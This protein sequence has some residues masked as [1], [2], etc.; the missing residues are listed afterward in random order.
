MGLRH[1]LGSV[2]KD[3]FRRTARKCA[4]SGSVSLAEGGS[5][6]DGL[7]RVRTRLA[8]QG[9]PEAFDALVAPRRAGLLLLLAAV[10][11]D[12]HEAEDAL[13]EVLWRVFRH[14]RDLRDTEALDPW[15]RSLALNAARDHLRA[16]AARLRREGTPLGD[17]AE[18]EAL[19]G[20]RA[21]L[22]LVSDLEDEA[23][24]R[25][26]LEALTVLPP[27]QRRAGSLAWVVSLPPRQ[28]AATLGV[29]VGGVHALLHRARRRLATSLG[30]SSGAGRGARQM[31]DGTVRISGWSHRVDPLVAHWRRT[32]PDLTVERV[33]L[34]ASD[35][36]VEVR[37]FWE[38]VSS[39][40]G[41]GEDGLLPLD[42][43][44]DAAGF[45]LEPFGDRLGP[46]CRDGRPLLLPWHSS[47]SSVLYN[48]DL[49]ERAGLPAP[50][51][52]WT[53]DEFLEYCRRCTAA[54]VLAI[55]DRRMLWG[56]D[57]PV[58]AEQLGASPGNVAPFGD[59]LALVR[60]WWHAAA[61]WAP[62][63]EDAWEHD[64]YA[65]GSVFAFGQWSW[66]P[67]WG[68]AEPE[69]HPRPFRW[70]I[71]PIPRLFRSAPHLPFWERSVVGVRAA[72]ADPVRAFA[73]VQAL[74]TD[75]PAPRGGELPAY[76]TRDAMGA[77]RAAALP[78]GK[79]CLLELDG[80]PPPRH[81][82]WL[83]SVEGMR[84][85]CRSAVEG[86]I[87]IAEAVTRIEAIVK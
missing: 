77:W 66:G 31:Q 43:L 34:G 50:S 10:I 41:S 15:L 33:D 20:P 27:L 67:Y 76:R 36:D 14:L 85:T 16:A 47:L 17:A 4:A 86:E 69:N 6:A 32:R 51:A 38:G 82:S 65:G 21:T 28:I 57:V 18:L 60:N 5:A 75:G 7:E 52:G 55:P 24:C 29:S 71:V 1:H 22:Q 80:V 19:A 63:R 46:F 23:A 84:E 12:W 2:R 81:A 9:D 53:W 74:F 79:E 37:P 83:N 13:Q 30:Q 26:I 3:D 42:A 49:L 40:P 39:E 8:A 54:G 61:A 87:T 44:A 56:D 78:L 35:A 25:S 45:D 68:F 70:G 73:V 62:L 59:A 48:A 11:G 58:V 72:A 64:F